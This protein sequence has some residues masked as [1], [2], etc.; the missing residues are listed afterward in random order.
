[1][2]RSSETL[3]CRAE[4]RFIG[5]D[6]AKYLIADF[7]QSFEE[8]PRL[9]LG[10]T[11]TLS[12]F[13]LTCHAELAEASLYLKPF[14]SYCFFWEI[15]LFSFFSVA[16]QRFPHALWHMCCVHRYT[17]GSRDGVTNV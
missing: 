10:M 6:F 4:S 16:M 8:I 3:R 12:S 17:G 13:L 9:L 15:D 1:M 11:K 2:L 7:L 5:I 14:Y